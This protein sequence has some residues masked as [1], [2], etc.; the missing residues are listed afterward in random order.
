MLL[1]SQTL[2]SQ[3]LWI[4]GYDI[5][6][7]KRVYYQG[8][9]VT[10]F[11]QPKG[12]VFF[13]RNSYPEYF[14]GLPDSLPPLPD[15]KYLLYSVDIK[16]NDT[17]LFHEWQM[18]DGKRDGLRIIYY[19]NGSPY[20]INQYKNGKPEGHQTTMDE[21]G[22]LWFMGMIKNGLIDG[23]CLLYDENE[24]LYSHGTYHNGKRIGK[25][26]HSA[27]PDTLTGFYILEEFD[28]VH[29]T[30]IKKYYENDSLIKVDIYKKNKI[31]TYI[32]GKRI[33]PEKHKETKSKSP[34]IF[35]FKGIRF[36]NDF[37][38]IDTTSFSAFDEIIA[39]LKERP[40][41]IIELFFY[42][43]IPQE[44][45]APKW[46]PVVIDYFIHSGIDASRIHPE[47]YSDN[48]PLNF[49]NNIEYLKNQKTKAT[50]IKK[51][52]RIAYS[53]TTN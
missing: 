30:S 17:T 13:N 25:W 36:S 10:A 33:R 11:Y 5:L 29:H 52:Q 2:M 50:L 45:L 35:L 49:E 18:K 23:D 22:N 47:F 26:T 15:G 38:D 46:I 44:N 14:T 20:K 4:E 9:S 41:L 3:K 42:C 40:D 53:F 51:N 21:S 31:I 1:L 48:A 7:T 12:L 28:T 43:P 32:D 37:S 24:M 6:D 19:E 8:D 39:H 27:S 16:S 34:K